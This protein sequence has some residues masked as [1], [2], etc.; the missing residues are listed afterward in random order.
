MSVCTGRTSI[1]NGCSL[2]SLGSPGS[3]SGNS[4]LGVPRMLLKKTGSAAS[5]TRPS[6]DN[7]AYRTE[8]Y[9][10]PQEDT[11]H[12]DLNLLLA[13]FQ[14]QEIF[15]P[16]PQART[17]GEKHPEM[18]VEMQCAHLTFFANTDFHHQ[19]RSG[20]PWCTH[21]RLHQ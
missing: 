3:S 11:V 5:F 16:M 21:R 6:S 18:H 17:R 15:S 4:L 8:L 1:C 2:G 19:K 12:C 10:M 13:R 14:E 9:L 7:S 20:F